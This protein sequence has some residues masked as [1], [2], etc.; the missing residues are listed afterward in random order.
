M[1]KV[2]QY[3]LVFDLHVPKYDKKA[4][5]ALMDFIS[6]NPQDGFIFGGDFLDMSNVSHHNKQKPRLKVRGGLEKDFQ[7][8]ERLLDEVESHLPRGCDKRIHLGNHED[9]LQDLL[10]EQPELEGS[11]D[12]GKRLRFKQRGW[13]EFG[14]GKFSRIGKL[15]VLHGESFNGVNAARK[16][17]DTLCQS[18]VMGHLHTYQAYTKVAPIGRKKWVGYIVPTMGT[19]AA[20]YAKGKPNACLHGFAIVEVQQNG[21]FCLYAPIITDGCFSY[22]GKLYGK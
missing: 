5:R 11:L 9:W 14:L 22:G 2:K 12:I 17:V 7:T 16:L 13:K 3:T 21:M 6:H 10:D 8:F 4:W 18:A 1:K 19:V 20:D 15:Q